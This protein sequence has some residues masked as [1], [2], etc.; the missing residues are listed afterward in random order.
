MR[1]LKPQKSWFA[2]Q[3]ELFHEAI[4][5]GGPLPVTLADARASLELITACYHASETQS[6]IHLPI[7]SEHPRY[8]GWAP[9][10]SDK[11]HQKVLNK[12]PAG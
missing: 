3:Y 9:V 7:K 6:V 11:P 5:T 8:G 4:A 1:E 2:R 12:L 10:T